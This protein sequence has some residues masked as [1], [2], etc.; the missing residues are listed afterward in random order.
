MRFSSAMQTAEL[1]TGARGPSAYTDGRK[2]KLS[3]GQLRKFAVRNC[4]LISQRFRWIG[5]KVNSGRSVEMVCGLQLRAAGR[6]CGTTKAKPWGGW[7]SIL[8]SLPA[9]GLK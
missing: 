2:K 1:P 7:K 5:G 3:A 4:A 8:T 9:S 6:R